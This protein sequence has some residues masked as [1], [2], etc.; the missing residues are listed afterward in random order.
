M[1]K[2]WSVAIFSITVVGLLHLY[3]KMQFNS[4]FN[5]VDPTVFINYMLTIY[6]RS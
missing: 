2:F 3:S 1:T 6:D 5:V 4:K